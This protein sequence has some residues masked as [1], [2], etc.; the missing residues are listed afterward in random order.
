M[1]DTPLADNGSEPR[2]TGRTILKAGGA[3]DAMGTTCSPAALLLEDDCIVACDAPEAIGHVADARVVELHDQVLLP[4]LVNAH[5]HLDLSGPGPWAPQVDFTAW[6]GQVRALRM[7]QRA[8]NV[9]AAV[10][11]GAQLSR[12]GG[13]IAVGDIV[14]DPAEPA[15][16]ALAASGLHGVA[17][18]EAFGHG[19]RMDEAIERFALHAGRTVGRMV[20][21][22]SPHAPYSCGRGVYEGAAMLAGMVATH[23]AETAEEC[24]LLADGTGPMRDLLVQHIGL[25]EALLPVY[26]AHPVDVLAEHLHGA[27]CVHLNH[28][29]PGHARRLA[30]VGA[31]ACMC[32]RAT[33]YFGR[34]VPG[35]L[36]T[37]LQAGVRCVLGTDSLLCLDTPDRI[38]VLDEARLLHTHVAASAEDLLAMITTNGAHAL[39][40]NEALVT[41]RPGPVG[42]VLALPGANLHDVLTSTALP[43][44]AAGPF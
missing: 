12:V 26:G 18:V 43:Q 30:Q 8:D 9:Q 22:F 39:G 40:L 16:L 6:V 19:P 5:T 36:P 15:L 3:V 31:V 29:E 20:G 10:E 27:L 23:L 34:P 42:G 13:S 35:P 24:A 41:L 21:G 14:G 17:F 33:A 7:H 2:R 11:R 44:W 38:S 32:P 1:H 28:I 25:P 37:L 4:G